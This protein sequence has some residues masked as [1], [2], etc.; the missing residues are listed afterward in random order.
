MQ[1]IPDAR[2]KMIYSKPER[3]TVCRLHQMQLPD[4]ALTKRSA[5]LTS[6]SGRGLQGDEIRQISPLAN[7]IDSASQSRGN[8]R[9]TMNGKKKTGDLWALGCLGF[10]LASVTANII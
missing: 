6:I 9:E 1:K 2:I 3:W 10:L 8:N 4:I 5:H 7:I